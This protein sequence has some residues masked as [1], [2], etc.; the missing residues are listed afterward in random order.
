MYIFDRDFFTSVNS[1]FDKRN[2]GFY[3]FEGGPVTVILTAISCIGLDTMKKQ[4]IVF[5][6]IIVKFKMHL[7]CICAN[8]IVSRRRANE[9]HSAFSFGYNEELF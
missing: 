9:S 8:F 5:K 4:I 1:G 2:V 6:E 7:S 3:L